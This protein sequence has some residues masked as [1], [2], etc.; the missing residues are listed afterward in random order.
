MVIILENNR[1]MQI[2][3]R[4]RK[5]SQNTQIHSRNHVNINIIVMWSKQIVTW[6]IMNIKIHVTVS[7]YSLWKPSRFTTETM[8]RW[9]LNTNRIVQKHM[10][11]FQKPQ[12]I[13]QETPITHFKFTGAS[14]WKFNSKL[15]PNIITLLHI[16]I[17]ITKI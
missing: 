8:C 7:T 3:P 4:I 14:G 1:I 9:Y 6:Y 16:H 10:G 12:E 15:Q 17:K 2:N 11:S 13:A 5:Y